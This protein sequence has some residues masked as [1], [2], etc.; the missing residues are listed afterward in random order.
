MLE[1][2]ASQAESE[3]KAEAVSFSKYQY[4]CKNSVKEL[5]AAIAEEKSTID[6]LADKIDAKMK[7]KATLEEEIAALDDQLAKMQA[8]GKK[9]DEAREKGAKLYEKNKKDLKDGIKAVEDCEHEIEHAEEVAEASLVQKRV[10]KQADKI[11]SLLQVTEEQSK[12]LKALVQAPPVD[13]YAF[14]GGDTLE[15]MKG[16]EH[17]FED[18]KVDADKAETNSINA[19]NL[20]KKARENAM[21]AAEASKDAKENALSACEEELSDAKAAKADTEEDLAADSA[22]LEETE[23]SCRVKTAEW[24]ER[25]KTREGEI[26][27]IGVA[28]KI[29]S[30][31]ADVRHEASDNP[32]PPPSPVSLLQVS[33]DSADPKMKAVDLLRTTAKVTHAK[34]LERLAQEIQAHLSAPFDEINAMVQKMIFRLMSEQKDED[35]HKNWCDK[36]LEKTDTIIENKEDKIETLTTKIEE[37]KAD[38]QDLAEDIKQAETMI[39]EIDTH[40]EESTDIRNEGKSENAISLKDAEDAQ[41][42][43]ANA[44]AV[45]EQFYKESGQVKKEEWEFL[46]RGVDLPD[47]PSTWDSGYTGVADPK[48]QPGGILTILEKTASEFAEMEADTTAQEAADQKLFEEDMKECT[49]EKARRTKES[50]MKTQEKNR[51]S[52]KIDA[53]TKSKKNTESELEATDQYLKDLQ[54]ACVSGDSSYEERKEA[55]ATEM[56]ALQKVQGILTDAFKESAAAGFP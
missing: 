31:V 5:N 17:K 48:E 16:L 10:Q 19:Y 8:A 56:K 41:A 47:E 9:A 7:E 22:T 13:E 2:L 28:V 39:S 12:A 42:A 24:T 32:V 35:D 1:G 23:K 26:E 18:D 21:D 33:K 27:A 45:L 54:K 51:L 11:L 55:R 14:K 4:W 43:V 29:L 20:A 53:L 40:V 38:V 50:D 3:G 30:K 49:I 34:A 15:L 46:Q 44:I 52:D 36:E 37:A 25:S 6:S